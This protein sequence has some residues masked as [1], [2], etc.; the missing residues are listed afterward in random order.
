[1][2]CDGAEEALGRDDV[3][4]GALDGLDD[5][6]GDL[7]RGLVADHVAD[8]VRARD[9]AVGIGRAQRAAIAVRIRRE[10]LAG[11]EGPQVMLEVAAEEP[12]DA[13]RL[14]VESAPEADDLVFP[15]GR[16]GEPQPGLHGLRAAREHLD[17][18]Q[19]LGGEGGEQ[20][21]EAGARLG[22]EAAERERLDLALERVDVVRMAV[23]DAADG[24][25]R[26]EVEVLVAVL[27]DE[28]RA[29]A[30]RHRQAGVEREGLKARRDVALL[31]RDDLLRPRPDLAPLAHRSPSSRSAH[32]AP[33]SKRRAR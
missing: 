16:L 9:A 26:D 29:L 2:D 30:A 4:G 19:A 15:G 25:A 7:A 33:P 27:V 11:Q 21:E 12:E 31:A 28:R 17:A 22:G 32:R 5:D 3:A 10:V 1:M 23:P 20:V 6:G 14:A 24:D 18:R 13:A 8:V